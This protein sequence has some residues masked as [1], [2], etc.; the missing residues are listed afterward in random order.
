ME[1]CV[2]DVVI[3]VDNL[4]VFAAFAALFIMKAAVFGIN[5]F[6]CSYYPMF[7]YFGNFYD[8]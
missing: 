5:F 7:C 2:F 8:W 4:A 3:S 6:S 1:Y